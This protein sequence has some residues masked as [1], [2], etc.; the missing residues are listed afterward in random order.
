VRDTCFR[1]LR[2]AAF[3]CCAGLVPV[4]PRT[5]VVILQHPRETRLAICS[6]WLA[7]IALAG[8]ELHRGVRFDDQPRVRE[9]LATPG[10]ALLYPDFD[11]DGA[12]LLG[13]DGAPRP[14]ASSSPETLIVIDATWPQATKMLRENP[15][16]TALPRVALAPAQASGYGDLRREPGPGHLS[17]IEA[18]ALALGQLEG[19]PERFEPMCE[20][21]RRSV[22]LQIA[23]ARGPRRSPRHRPPRDGT[24]NSNETT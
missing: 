21:F 23:V 17:T 9:L 16:L 20:A 19:E 3:C 4:A 22:A 10:T 2:P 14:P 1:C 8:S 12:P 24:A 11:A 15:A 18:I 13:P 6:A 7:H 5:R